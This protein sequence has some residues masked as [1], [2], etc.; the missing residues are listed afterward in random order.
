MGTRE[1]DRREIFLS[2]T[3]AFSDW[4]GLVF[5]LVCYTTNEIFSLEIFLIAVL[6]GGIESRS[7]VPRNG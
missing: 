5:G 2:V 6:I 1:R 4:L 3:L 7:R